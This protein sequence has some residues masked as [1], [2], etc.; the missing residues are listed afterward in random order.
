MIYLLIRGGLISTMSIENIVQFALLALGTL[1]ALLLAVGSLVS[2]RRGLQMKVT[3]FHVLGVSEDTSVFLLRLSFVNN[4]SVG[5]VVYDIVPTDIPENITLSKAR[6][7]LDLSHQNVV[8]QL[9]TSGEMTLPISEVLLPPLDILPH[10]SLSI[11]Y[12]MEMKVNPKNV[13]DSKQVVA[14]VEKLKLVVHLKAV[15]MRLKQVASLP[16]SGKEILPFYITS[17]PTFETPPEKPDHEFI[18]MFSDLM[19]SPSFVFFLFF[20][21]ILLIIVTTL[22]R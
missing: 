4:S 18:F 20:I 6:Y 22:W 9:P 10:Q 13:A 12:G 14:S 2:S 15:D 8:Y 16:S 1:I 21:L 7:T 17:C 19:G 3:Y 5:R 11:W